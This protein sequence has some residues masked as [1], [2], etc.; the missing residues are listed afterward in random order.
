MSLA[1]IKMLLTLHVSLTRLIFICFVYTQKMH[2]MIAVALS[3]LT[4]LD[5]INAQKTLDQ[6]AAEKMNDP[7]LTDRKYLTYNIIVMR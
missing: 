6:L 4:M 2:L 1:L 5:L 7:T 3:F